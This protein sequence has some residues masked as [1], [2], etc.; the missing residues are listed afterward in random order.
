MDCKV[1]LL[2]TP[3]HCTY[4][5]SIT[6]GLSLPYDLAYEPY[7]HIAD[8][9]ARFSAIVD[10]YDA[11]CTTGLFSRMVILRTH[12]ECVKPVC[13][14]AE[15]VAE[16]YRL[17]LKL[18][19][20]NRDMDL[21][22]VFF[23]HSLWLSADPP[24][25]AL[26]YLEG[27]VE[28]GEGN[29][30]AFLDKLSLDQLL[31]ADELISRRALQFYDRGLLDLV[32]C[33]HSSV[34]L[35][36]KDAGL[37]CIFAYPTAGNV[38]TSLERLADDIALARMGEN[39]PGVIMLS[40][41]TLADTGPEDVTAESIALQKCLLD[42]D[43]ENTAGMLIKRAAGGF[44]LYT[45]RHTLQRLTS[46]FTLCALSRYLLGRLGV[47][48]AV[49]YGIGPDIM[50]ARSRAVKA[51]ELAQRSGESQLVDD[52]GAR[53]LLP[54]SVDASEPAV[55]QQLQAAAQKAGL[56]VVTLQRIMSATELLGRRE[57]TTQELAAALQVT[58][59]NA[60]RF[61]NQL[62]TAGLAQVVGERKALTRGRPTRVYRLDI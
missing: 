27:T 28:F 1:A 10:R 59:A 54:P 52:S 60:N 37:P 50:T 43:Q 26:D 7:T 14:I 23:D 17:L 18:L 19:Y 41:P 31:Q 61:M 34:Y 47:Q 25:T 8:L 36:L 49:G 12:P 39:Q 53:P 44:E 21:S 24:V 13:A 2:S 15:S 20:Q 5:R 35:T 46:Q 32:V 30:Q 3:E 56:S 4:L 38:R 11:F 48:P 62:H 9:P 33:R 55:S 45:T 29:R 22:R 40:S 16:F 58:V 51:A 57:L 42:F 6:D